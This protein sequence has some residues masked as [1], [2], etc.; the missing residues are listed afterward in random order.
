MAFLRASSFLAASW[1]KTTYRRVFWFHRSCTVALC[2][3]LCPLPYG[4]LPCCA[5]SP[6]PAPQARAPQ[7]EEDGGQ[8]R[9]CG[10]GVRCGALTAHERAQFF[11]FLLFSL[12][13]HE[14]VSPPPPRSPPPAGSPL[15]HSVLLLQACGLPT[16]CYPSISL[17]F[18]QETRDPFFFLFF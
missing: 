5:R 10:R 11:F 14:S 2:F 7:S 16:H 13:S 8:P 15:P 12:L 18:R 1:N 17:F 4:C 6:V 3:H 9:S